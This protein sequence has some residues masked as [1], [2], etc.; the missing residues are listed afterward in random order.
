MPVPVAGATSR[1]PAGVA[2]TSEQIASALEYLAPIAKGRGW[3]LD[4]FTHHAA[5]C[6]P[7]GRKRDLSEANWT[8]LQIALSRVYP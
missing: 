7:K 1:H 6:V 3:S 8:A 4:D 5:V 2:L